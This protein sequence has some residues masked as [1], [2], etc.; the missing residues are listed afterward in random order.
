MYIR[1]NQIKIPFPTNFDPP[2]PLKVYDYQDVTLTIFTSKMKLNQWTEQ[3][4]QQKRLIPPHWQVEKKIKNKGQSL[5]FSFSSGLQITVFARRIIFTLKAR[6][7]QVDLPSI[8]KKLVLIFPNYYYDRLQIVFRR[9][10]TFPSKKYH[11]GRFINEKILNSQQ[12]DVHG[13]KPLKSQVNLSVTGFNAPLTINISDLSVNNRKIKANSGLLF[14]GIFDYKITK[15]S[16]KNRIDSLITTI[17]DYK[18]IKHKF[19][20]VIEKKILKKSS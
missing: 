16:S 20:Q 12:W 6:D 5:V 13:S 15:Q 4:W 17:A 14:R 19:N 1:P 3:I 9:I 11:A 2:P 18:T 8:I 7:K 10:I